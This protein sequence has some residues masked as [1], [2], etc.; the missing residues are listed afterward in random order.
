MQIVAHIASHGGS[1]AEADCSGA[2]IIGKVLKAD[3]PRVDLY[4]SMAAS[5]P[6]LLTSLGLTWRYITQTQLVA[7][8]QE[9]N[10]A[11]DQFMNTAFF[12]VGMNKD[13]ILA[14]GQK[15][16][17]A[18]QRTPGLPCTT[19][20]AYIVWEYIIAKIP[21][22]LAERCDKYKL[23]LDHAVAEGAQPKWTPRALLVKISVDIASL[24]KH[25]TSAGTLGGGGGA[26]G[27]AAGGGA[28]GGGV[29][30]GGGPRGP[31]VPVC[32]QCEGPHAAPGKA[33]GEQRC[34]DCKQPACMGG[35]PHAGVRDPV[36]GVPKDT[37]ICLACRPNPIPDTVYYM[38][39]TKAPKQLVGW[40]R[41][42]QAKLAREASAGEVQAAA[43]AA[44]AE[45]GATVAG[46]GA[47][48]SD[49]ATN[50]AIEGAAAE[51]RV[52]AHGCHPPQLWHLP[53]SA[54]PTPS[55][56]AAAQEP[57]LAALDQRLAPSPPSLRLAP[58]AAL[59][60]W[61]APL[62]AQRAARSSPT[63]STP[64]LAL[65]GSYPLA[66]TA[67]RPRLA[68]VA[69][70][71]L[72]TPTCTPSPADTAARPR[73]ASVARQRLALLARNSRRCHATRAIACYYEL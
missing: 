28:G 71:R 57:R 31:P 38:N 59:A 56:L 9:A 16:I 18:I 34:Q 44:E 39:G 35:W 13:T 66:Q 8:G 42:A 67:A 62:A 14:Q 10:L 36:P 48:A 51:V 30:G 55:P 12:S 52:P 17:L 11:R 25:E 3:T 54:T 27:G 53:L 65:C 73:L 23:K 19:S 22:E 21:N 63:T 70:Q 46:G 29:G 24:T 5:R 6:L 40:L 50:T 64:R 47:I 72:A 61:L 7:P 37:P 4:T 26:G 32:P 45:A 15:L 58:L 60:A 41:E 68:L 49:A 69:R 20:Q 2:R 43:A 1:V 33:C